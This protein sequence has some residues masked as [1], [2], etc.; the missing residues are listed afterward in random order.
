MNVLLINPCKPDIFPPPSLGFLNAYLRQR[1]SEINIRLVDIDAALE[2]KEHEGPFDIIGVTIHSFALENVKSVFSRLST[3]YRNS[4]WVA[5][6]HHASA[7]PEQMLKLGFDQVVIGPGEIAFEEIIKGNREQKIIGKMPDDSNLLSFPDYTGLKGLWT[8]PLHQ[9]GRA[10][11]VISSRGCPFNCDFCASANFWHRKSFVRKPENV[12]EE[13]MYYLKNDKMDSFMFEDDNF[14]LI[15]RRAI[16]ICEAIETRIRP[17]YSN[18][19]WQAAS[20]AESLTNDDLCHALV[21][22]G[23]THVWLGI[24]SGSQTML[25]GC[26]KGTTTEKM[27]AGIMNAE[28]YG[29]RTVGQ[30]I[31][32]LPG[33]TEA[34]IKETEEF[35]LKSKMSVIMVNKPWILPKTNL[36][37]L[38]LNTGFNDEI[39]FDNVPFYTIETAG[40]ILDKWVEQLHKAWLRSLSESFPKRFYLEKNIYLYENSNVA[41]AAIEIAKG[42]METKQFNEAVEYLSKALSFHEQSSGTNE[43]VTAVTAEEL[44]KCYKESGHYKEAAEYFKQAFQYYELYYGMGNSSTRKV[45][46]ELVYCSMRIEGIGTVRKYLITDLILIKCILKYFKKL[47]RNGIKKFLK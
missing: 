31:V 32:G 33:E 34:T 46:A 26:A 28:R 39:Y 10:L 11:P 4:W 45:L 12:I 40:K 14:T 35:I 38:A 30:F 17:Y 13:I 18:L 24:E 29:L 22:A 5:G 42:L 15:P 25:E 7:L 43:S 37:T 23:C 3:L 19:K 2:L 1:F 9:G 27:L 8:L 47:I 6:G 36:H 44:A 20:R 21:N 16:E 41:A